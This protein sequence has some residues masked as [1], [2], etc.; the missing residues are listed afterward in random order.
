MKRQIRFAPDPVFTDILPRY[1]ENVNDAERNIAESTLRA[2]FLSVFHGRETTPATLDWYQRFWRANRDLYECL[3]KEPEPPD[4]T[5]LEKVEIGTARAERLQ[6]RF[7]LA[8]R[9]TD[10]DL[11]DRPI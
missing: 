11:W 7:L 4:P 1:P 2:M 9:D 3:R 6:Y 10:P 5:D 8:S